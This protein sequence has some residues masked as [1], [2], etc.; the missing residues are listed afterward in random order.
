[1]ILTQPRSLRSVLS[2]SAGST[3][4]VGGTLSCGQLGVSILG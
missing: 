3:L 2:S 4:I 1:M